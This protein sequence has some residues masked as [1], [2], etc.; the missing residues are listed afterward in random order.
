M[1]SGIWN[2]RSRPADSAGLGD[3][4]V[5][6]DALGLRESSVGDQSLEEV[7]V[8]GATL[9]AE[10]DDEGGQDDQASPVGDHQCDRLEGCERRC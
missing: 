2:Q 3:Q 4:R 7:V 1:A 6:N 5:C 9:P 10:A 8:L